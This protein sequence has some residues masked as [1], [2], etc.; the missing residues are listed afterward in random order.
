[1]PTDVREGNEVACAPR[2][3]VRRCAAGVADSRGGAGGA[4]GAGVDGG[5]DEGEDEGEDLRGEL[6]D[7]AARIARFMDAA[8]CGVE[9]SKDGGRL[10]AGSTAALVRFSPGSRRRKG[11]H[12]VVPYLA[13]TG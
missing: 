2:A 4:G 13:S 11:G 1:M 3:A 10:W 12:K 7:A 5:G 8:C 9:P 6:V